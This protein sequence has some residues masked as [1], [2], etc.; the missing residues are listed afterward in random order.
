[1]YVNYLFRRS[2]GRTKKMQEDTFITT[3]LNKYKQKDRRLV[4]PTYNRETRTTIILALYDEL[5]I[6]YFNRF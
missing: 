4:G 1:M 5:S 2:F 6:T 3:Y